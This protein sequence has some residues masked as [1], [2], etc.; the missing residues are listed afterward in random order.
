MTKKRVLFAGCSFTA[1]CGF[2]ELNRQIYHWPFLLSNHYDFYFT[3]VAIGGMS[4]DEI[5]YRT[6]E[7]LNN[8][9]YD[10]VCVMWSELDRSW[11]YHSTQNIDD[12]TVI[13]NG[14]PIGTIKNNLIYQYAKLHVTE[15]N[16]RYVKLKHWLI[17]LLAL[18]SFLKEKNIP[19]CF[20]KSFDNLIKDVCNANYHNDSFCQLSENL[21]AILNFDLSPDYYILE[22][23]TELKQLLRKIDNKN[24]LNL[25]GDAC[26]KTTNA[27]LADD[28]SH[29]GIISNQVLAQKL[30]NFINT[31][32]YL[33]S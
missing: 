18:E 11:T 22:K 13:N 14:V 16:N 3:N 6:I 12:W 7:E 27:D 24:W 25:Y 15:F 8:S 33:S 19:Y 21:R 4:N 32:R 31:N 5:F 10:F 1:D 26:W 29:P 23:L 20:I 17:Q 2:N 28:Q 9:A 30:I